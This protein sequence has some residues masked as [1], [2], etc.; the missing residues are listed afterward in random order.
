MEHY[1]F[2]TYL[3]LEPAQS[4]E[5][6]LGLKH[7]LPKFHGLVGVDPHK[8]LKEFHVVCSTMRP[9]HSRQP[10]VGELV[11]RVNIN[12]EAARYRTISIECI[13]NIFG[14]MQHPAKDHSIFSID[15]IDEIEAQ[16]GNWVDISRP[17]R[18]QPLLEEEARPIRLNLTFLNVVKKKVIKLLV[19]EVVY[20]IP[21]SQW[22]SPFQV[23]P[24]KS[25]M[26]VMKNQHDEMVTHKDHFRLPFIDQVLEK[27]AE[28]S[29]YCFLDGFF[30]TGGSALDDLYVSLRYI[31][32]VQ[33]SKYIP[34]DWMEVFMDDFTMYANSFDACL[35]NLSQVLRRCMDTNLILNFEK[36]HFMVTKGIVLGHLVSS[37]GIE[38]DK[39]KVDIFLLYLTHLYVESS[40][41]PWTC[42]HFIKNFTKIALPLSKLLQKDVAF[43]FDKPCVDAFQEL[44]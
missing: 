18:D 17:S 4:Y 9:W 7:L 5:L 33:R 27:L 31:W 2:V 29:H 8:H 15:I 44:R 26:T 1:S 13:F 35:E 19:V 3:Q 12:S 38:V 37:K 39:A 10:K 25:S 42:R 22:V 36:C 40:L 21:Y 28:K 16:E 43:V 11:D 32:I 24:K 30:G 6:K 34:G 41:F 23:V 14:A 20:P